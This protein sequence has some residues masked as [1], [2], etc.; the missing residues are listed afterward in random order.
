MSGKSIIIFYILNLNYNL[1]VL[2][3]YRHIHDVRLFKNLLQYSP[4]YIM[5]TL[6]CYADFGLVPNVCTNTNPQ[7]YYKEFVW[8]CIYYR[9]KLERNSC[10]GE[11]T[12]LFNPR[13]LIQ[14]YHFLVVS[15]LCSFYYLEL[16]V[17]YFTC[18]FK[19]QIIRGTTFVSVYV[20]TI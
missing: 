5:M 13:V 3:Y 19:N 16:M 4:S 7:M 14:F 1:A 18:I 17:K 8:N 12:M 2:L 9:P 15:I 10:I 20:N 6:I 11:Q